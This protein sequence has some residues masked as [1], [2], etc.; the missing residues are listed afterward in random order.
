MVVDT[1]IILLSHVARC[2]T[3]V[4]LGASKSNVSAAAPP[5][6]TIIPIIPIIPAILPDDDAFLVFG[7]PCSIC[8]TNFSSNEVSFSDE[9]YVSP[10]TL[11]KYSLS[12]SAKVF[13][14]PSFLNDC[15]SVLIVFDSLV[16]RI[17]PQLL[18]KLFELGFSVPHSIQN[19]ISGLSNVCFSEF[20]LGFSI[21]FSVLN[22]DFTAFLILGKFVGWSFLG[23]IFFIFIR[24]RGEEY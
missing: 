10:V 18:Q 4:L 20:V 15:E 17:E 1:S 7:T 5:A 12:Y 21:F 19:F 14:F 23:S 16:D 11:F 9:L 2:N 8:L 24:W 3:V 13:F 22:S 6:I